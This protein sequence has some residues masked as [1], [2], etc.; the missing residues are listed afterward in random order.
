M[1]VVGI[2]VDLVDIERVSRALTRFGPRFFQRIL[3]ASE[4]ERLPSRH[5][6]ATL[7]C[8]GRFAA[9]E[10]GV[11]ALGTGFSQGI[12]PTDIQVRALSSGQPELLFAGLAATRAELLGVRRVHLSLTHSRMMACAMVVLED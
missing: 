12:A 10:A 8:A 4:V 6:A 2:G 11:K 1:A 3:T 9:K 7:Y 5:D